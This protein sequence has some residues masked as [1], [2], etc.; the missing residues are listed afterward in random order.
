MEVEIYSIPAVN[1]PRLEEEIEKLNRRADKLGTD[2]IKL[3]VHRKVAMKQKD[4]ILGFMYDE[5]YFECS[6]EGRVPCLEGW[7]LI[8]VLESLP[9]D[10]MLV[11]EVPGQMCP[12]RFRITDLHCDHCHTIR[13]RN[14]IYVMRHNERGYKKVGRNCLRDFFG[15]VGP[16]NLL[17]NAEYIFDF[18][19]LVKDAEEE[20]WGF[21]GKKPKTVVDI[22]RFVVVVSCVV[23]KIGW[24]PRSKQQDDYEFSVP[25][26]TAN[27]AWRVCTQP[28][29]EHV[30]KFIEQNGIVAEDKDIQ[31]TTDALKWAA[32]IDPQG[33]SSTYLHDLGVCC[34][35]EVVEW[36][37]A[38][39]VASVINAYQRHLADELKKVQIASSSTSLHVGTV[40]K[41]EV[42][43]QVTCTLIKPYMS[44]V[45]QKT[46][47]KFVDPN[48]NT[49]I[50]CASGQPEWVRLGEKYD[51]KAT[52][53]KHS[54]YN[55]VP[56][57]EIK[58]VVPIQEESDE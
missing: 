31:L 33:A 12:A 52:V 25:E 21:G 49:F 20:G 24:M 9:N 35:Q 5:V 3:T 51:V 16:E 11:R 2:P 26:P 6:V 18:K 50:W 4:P 48:N 32:G 56:Q 40:G 8:A 57:T 41:R 10:E 45:Y 15:G 37:T 7:T 36:K 34:R 17:V 42:F 58:R 14:S 38:G 43:K 28:K 39:Y 54:D 23:R 53:E 29:D 1:F 46:L 44:G 13:R 30:R 22:E 19:K 55:G 27:I 47:F